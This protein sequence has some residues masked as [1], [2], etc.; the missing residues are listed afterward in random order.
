MRKGRGL[1]RKGATSTFSW[2]EVIGFATA[3]QNQ[4]VANL[5]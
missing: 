5:L 1:R 4:G 2:A 3:E